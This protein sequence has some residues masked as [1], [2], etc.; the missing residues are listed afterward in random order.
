MSI[1]PELV[2]KSDKNLKYTIIT[3]F[4]VEAYTTT[5]LYFLVNAD[6]TDA[7]SPP[8]AEPIFP[9]LTRECFQTTAITLG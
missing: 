1:R 2:I 6:E 5:T 8:L 7:T 9:Q 4:K 3:T